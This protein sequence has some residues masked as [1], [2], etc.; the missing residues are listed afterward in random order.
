MQRKLVF[1]M[2]LALFTVHFGLASIVQNNNPSV[3][4]RAEAELLASIE[5]IE[6]ENSDQFDLG[7][8]VYDYLPLDFDPYKGMIYSLD[9]IEFIKPDLE[10]DF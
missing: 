7:F 9:E 2:S 10:L 5:Y 8:N 6:E 3:E 4:E 1:V